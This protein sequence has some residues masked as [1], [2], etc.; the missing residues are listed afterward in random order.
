MTINTKA[1]MQMAVRKAITGIRKNKGGPFGA[2]I[3]KNG[4]VI[5]TGCNTVTSANDPTAHAEINAIRQ[6][7]KKLGNFDLSG[8]VMYATC[9]PCPMCLS[10][11]HWA[12][13]GKVIYGCTRKDAAGIGFDDNLLYEILKGRKKW[14]G[15]IVQMDRE[16]CLGIFKEWAKKADKKRY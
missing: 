5:S 6:A 3:A 11:I 2:V 4:K 8:C 15:S 9:E 7:G 14:N 13:I 1:F 16:A 12:R 10:A